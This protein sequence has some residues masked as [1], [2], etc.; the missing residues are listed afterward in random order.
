MW[1]A[2]HGHCVQFGESAKSCECQ[3]QAFRKVNRIQFRRID[4]CTAPTTI[5]K[6]RKKNVFYTQSIKVLQPFQIIIPEKL[7]KKE[8]KVICQFAE[9]T[10][11]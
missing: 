6:Q 7:I 8:N 10:N 3:Q 4:F 5:A 11:K 9:K 2:L 1:K